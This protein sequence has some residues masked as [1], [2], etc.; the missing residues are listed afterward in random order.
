[1]HADWQC[2]AEQIAKISFRHLPVKLQYCCLVSAKIYC[3]YMVTLFRSKQL[4][5]TGT[6][7][8]YVSH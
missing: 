7:C 3:H 2:L 5:G 6:K 1:M 8:T 4:E